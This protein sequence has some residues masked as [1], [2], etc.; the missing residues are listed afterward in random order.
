MKKLL[1]LFL[2]VP[3]IVFGQRRR[4]TGSGYIDIYKKSEIRQLISDSLSST[5]VADTT[6][7]KQ[8]SMSNGRYCYLKQL[9]SSTN[10]GGG[11]FVLADSAYPEGGIAFDA[12]ETGKQWVRI[13]YIKNHIIYP[14]WFSDKSIQRAINFADSGDVIYL[15][16]DNYKSEDL[17]LKDGINIIA[18]NDDIVTINGSITF[19]GHNYISGVAT[20]EL[21]LS[22]GDTVI[23]QDCKINDPENNGLH[24]LITASGGE[25]NFNN[26][27]SN[28]TS[29]Q[30]GIYAYGLAQLTFSNCFIKQKIKLEDG[31]II[32]FKNGSK[33]AI[34]TGGSIFISAYDTS[35]FY[36]ESSNMFAT[37]DGENAVDGVGY[38]DLTFYNQS[39]G[40]FDNCSTTHP[41]NVADSAKIYVNN[42]TAMWSGRF[43]SA[44]GVTS[45]DQALIRA[46]NFYLH[47]DNGGLVGTHNLEVS[48]GNNAVFDLANG[49]IE[50]MGDKG[51]YPMVGDLSA[52]G[53]TQIWRNLVLI[54]HGSALNAGY[55][56]D[57]KM[58]YAMQHADVSN[59]TFIWGAE[60]AVTSGHHAGAILIQP[61]GKNIKTILSN[62][63]V[64]MP[65]KSNDRYALLIN[66]SADSI[67]TLSDSVYLDVHQI[68]CA[69]LVQGFYY[70]NYIQDRYKANLNKESEYFV[71]KLFSQYA[72]I[73]NLLMKT[74][75]MET[76][77][78]KDG[79]VPLTDLMD[80]LSLSVSDT[81]IINGKKHLERIWP[82]K[83][84]YAITNLYLPEKL[85]YVG[86]V[87][88]RTASGNYPNGYIV[89]V[90]ANNDIF[91]FFED[92]GNV[93]TLVKD[94]NNDGYFYYQNLYDNTINSVD[95][96]EVHSNTPVVSDLNNVDAWIFVNYG[97]ASL[98]RIN[99]DSL[100][101]FFDTGVNR[102]NAPIYLEFLMYIGQNYGA[103]SN[104]SLYKITIAYN[105]GTATNRSYIHADTLYQNS[106]SYDVS[107]I[108][109]DEYGTSQ[110]NRW[111]R[112]VFPGT[113]NSSQGFYFQF[114]KAY[115][116]KDV[117][118]SRHRDRY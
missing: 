116:V 58:A 56:Y 59:C 45:T 11:W 102:V 75:W 93:F 44:N 74:Q 65:H 19:V 10:V 91:S 61:V 88:V 13:S 41:L 67:I 51:K 103:V 90:D 1:L 83:D 31:A 117:Y 48:V 18:V 78:Q 96:F 79:G 32:K 94:P 63:T 57:D 85:K 28:F 95:T 23:M 3:L 25:A 4:V 109:I 108:A 14:Q 92:R 35:K 6:H 16:S 22:D 27:E 97:I 21:Y 104:F 38:N 60:H 68:G 84:I 86:K 111:L 66:E 54:D 26:C 69:G 55:S 101:L 112:V 20:N 76:I 81:A 47:M 12:P 9:S 118:Y 82:D 106:Y 64:Y 73:D 36:F 87:N 5:Y 50:Y 62:V 33:L 107:K 100:Y 39:K 43:E 49:V 77:S 113:K 70:Y 110:D 2:L 8:L 53:G 98:S 37:A 42:Y 114:L 71:S 80:A 72:D 7:L 24:I 105:Y 17:I 30:P 99:C 115:G 46:R 40:Y 89:P 29:D 52:G 34:P 15:S